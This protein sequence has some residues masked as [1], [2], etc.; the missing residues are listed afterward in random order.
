M[1]V[2]FKLKCGLREKPNSE[3]TSTW[4]CYHN[5]MKYYLQGSEKIIS[6]L[7]MSKMSKILNMLLDYIVHLVIIQTMNSKIIIGWPRRV[8]HAA[9]VFLFIWE[10]VKLKLIFF[11]FII[12]WI[13]MFCRAA[14]PPGNLRESVL[15]RLVF[16]VKY[17]GKP[18]RFWPVDFLLFFKWERTVS[19]VVIRRGTTKLVIVFWLVAVGTDVIDAAAVHTEYWFIYRIILS[20]APQNIIFFFFFTLKCVNTYVI[21]IIHYWLVYFL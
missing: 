7:G 13:C 5:K 16:I 10:N 18:L 21:F 15:N 11:V 9:S 2:F 19:R 3:G 6:L 8:L 17:R 4:I 20:R 12:V 14:K 1:D